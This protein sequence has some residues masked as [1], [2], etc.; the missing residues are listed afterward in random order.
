MSLRQSDNINLGGAGCI[1]EHSEDWGQAPD[2]R[3]TPGG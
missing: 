2:G 1:R 3:S